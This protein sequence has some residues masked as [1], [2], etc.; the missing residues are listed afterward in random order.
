MCSLRLLDRRGDRDVGAASELR[1]QRSL[2]L[3]LPSFPDLSRAARWCC[4]TSIRP[5]NGA[6]V[7]VRRGT[8]SRLSNMS[9]EAHSPVLGDRVLLGGT[10]WAHGVPEIRVRINNSASMFVPIDGFTLG[11]S[12]ANASLR[13]VGHKP[14]RDRATAWV[15]CDRTPLHE[16][17][18]CDRCAANDA[19]FASQ[20]H[21]AHMRGIGEL[22]SSVQAHLDQVNHLYL[23]AF[24]D[25]S[26]KVGTSTAH[27]VDTRLAEQGAWRAVIV[28]TTTNGIAVREIE[29]HVTDQLGLPQSVTARRKLSGLVRPVP[30]EQLVSELARWGSSV[31]Q[32]IESTASNEV[33]TTTIEWIT[34]I[35]GDDVWNH[36]IAY[37]LKL[38]TGAHQLEMIAASGR[39]CAFTRPRQHDVFV[40]DLRSLYG[41]EVV[42]SNVEPDELA[43]QDSLF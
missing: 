20:L 6:S 21:H 12:S 36:V 24:R 15:D 22:D 34:P 2:G 38:R 42:H 14:F 9:T 13:C 16:G 5:G 3:A 23:A 11:Y 33:T 17:S 18:A 31:H 19:V 29:A 35:D 28:A 27:R 7:Q 39:L 1:R 4:L 26:I 32:L 43:V 8:W 30:N 25:G 40:A 10:S 41:F 37:P